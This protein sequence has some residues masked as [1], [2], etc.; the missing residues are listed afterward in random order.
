MNRART[1]KGE[2]KDEFFVITQLFSRTLAY[3]IALICKQIGLTA[4]AVTI[5][6]GLLWVL[7][8]PTIIV[9]GYL[10]DGGE[11]GIATNLIIAAVALWN[12]GYILDVVDGSLARMTGTSSSSGYFLDFCFHL[13]FHPMFLCSIGGFLF[14]LTD[15]IFYLILAVLSTFT[16][17]GVSFGAKE[18]VLCEHIA[19]GETD[20]SQIPQDKR[21]RIYIDSARTR[22][23]T[24]EKRGIKRVTALFN[25]VF[26]FPGQYTLVSL[27]VIADLLLS[28]S[29]GPDFVL[30]QI[31][32][33]MLTTV[34]LIRVPFRL[35][36]EFKTLELYDEMR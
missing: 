30:L 5:L 33:V 28:L 6:G 34:P 7:S 2:K 29:S 27:V 36:R 22:Q 1:N 10:W 19:K 21:Y 24:Q 11:T 4:N 23:P 14:L 9:A 12:L 35:R 3:P 32:F 17:W 13:I 18:H 31:A 20:P 8:V 16:G 15:Q 25:E 26:C